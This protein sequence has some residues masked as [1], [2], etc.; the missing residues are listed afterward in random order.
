MADRDE[1]RGGS[2][3]MS[4]ALQWAV[5]A[6]SALMLLFSGWAA[7]NLSKLTDADAVRSADMRVLQTEIQGIKSNMAAS[8]SDRYTKI[9]ARADRLVLRLDQTD[10]KGR[11]HGR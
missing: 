8:S 6:A 10:E 3:R 1:D 4:M 9:D 11:P 7:T 5:S 2:V